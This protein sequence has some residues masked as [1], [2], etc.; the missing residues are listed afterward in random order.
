MIQTKP[1]DRWHEG[2]YSRLVGL[3]SVVVGPNN[4]PVIM[5]TYC[6]PT[7]TMKQ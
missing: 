3:Q 2:C 7:K 1:T 5:T 6:F 4:A